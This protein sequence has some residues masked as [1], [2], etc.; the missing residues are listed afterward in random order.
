[1]LNRFYNP[2]DLERFPENG[3][4]GHSE[5][6]SAFEIERARIVFSYPFRRLQ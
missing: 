4:P 5:Y 1:M 6:R 2:F 3:K